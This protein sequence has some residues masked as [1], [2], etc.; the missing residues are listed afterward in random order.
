MPTFT[1]K[2]YKAALRNRSARTTSAGGFSVKNDNSFIVIFVIA[3]MVFVFFYAV[4]MGFE[5]VRIFFENG[6]IRGGLLV[7][8]IASAAWH[9]GARRQRAV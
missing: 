5:L 2:D 8:F 1:T 3:M 6:N 7:T 9:R 4:F